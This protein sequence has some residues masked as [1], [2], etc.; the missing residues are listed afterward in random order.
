MFSRGVALP[1]KGEIFQVSHS[2]IAESTGQVS[3]S[4]GSLE[5]VLYVKATETGV[6]YGKNVYTIV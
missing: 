2:G 3:H 5:I 6:I 1:N 4:K